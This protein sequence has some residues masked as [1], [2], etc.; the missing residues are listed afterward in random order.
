MRTKEEL[1]S[2]EFCDDMSELEAELKARG[3]EYTIAKHPGALE[4]DGKVK[5]LIGYY[6]TG[7][8]H[9]HVGDV[10]IIRGSVSFGDYECY[11]GK[12]KEPERFSDV[13]ELVDDLTK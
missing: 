12:Y 10:S 7:E 2:Y 1:D 6:P 13:K 11:R 5:E 4:G 3:I 9:I 8:W